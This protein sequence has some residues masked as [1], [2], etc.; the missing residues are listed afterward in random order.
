MILIHGLY[1]FPWMLKWIGSQLEKHFNVVYFGHN[2][3]KFGEATMHSL[4]ELVMSLNKKGVKKVI[5]AGHSMGGLLAKKYSQIH[6]NK[7]H[8]IVTFGTPHQGS[9]MG[10]LLDT[11]GLIGTAGDSGIT[12]KLTE[13]TSVPFLNIVGSIK[14]PFL[15]KTMPLLAHSDGT[16]SV[17]EAKTEHATKEVEVDATHLGLLTS[18]EVISEILHFDKNL[19]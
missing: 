8:Y 10:K 3:V 12:K 5:L 4:H 6:D 18:Q 1:S 19:T 7:L 11:C 9:K 17:A 2:S 15:Q 13:E 14:N 16:V